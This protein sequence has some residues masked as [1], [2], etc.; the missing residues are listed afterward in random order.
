MIVI[1]VVISTSRSALYEPDT[2][3]ANS[4]SILGRDIYTELNKMVTLK[5]QICVRDVCLSRFRAGS[6]NADDWEVF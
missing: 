2:S 4:F 3:G 6:Y 1:C 5:Q